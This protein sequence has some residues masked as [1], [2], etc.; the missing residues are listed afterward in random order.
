MVFLYCL[1]PSVSCLI[2]K[3]RL[4]DKHPSVIALCNFF[5]KEIQIAE[6]IVRHFSANKCVYM[7]LTLRGSA[8]CHCGVKTAKQMHASLDFVFLT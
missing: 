4:F 1:G 3:H 8:G 5:K 6:L 2:I 7:L